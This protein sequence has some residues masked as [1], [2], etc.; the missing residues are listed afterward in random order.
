MRETAVNDPAW[1]I[2]NAAIF[3][4]G[5]LLLPPQPVG[6][7]ETA[8]NLDEATIQTLLKAAKDKN[9][10]VRG[11][12]ISILATTKDKKYV[13]LY[14][15]ALKDQ[16]YFV[17]DQAA[18]ALGNTKDDRAFNS[19]TK[20]LGEKSW[21]NKI[22]ISA[23]NGL[24]A[25]ADKRSL[26]IGIKYA[27]DKTLPSNSRTAALTVVGATGKGDSRAFP[28]IFDSFKTALANNSFQGINN[29]IQAII[30]LGD[31]R[32]QEAIDLL[33][34]KFKDNQQ[35]LSYIIQLEQQFKKSLENK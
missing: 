32:G 31:P 15:S 1:Q 22:E 19:L 26:E 3:K 5:K 27:G 6:S 35:F 14:V 8:V 28:L 10:Q 2:R 12:A 4:I 18:L 33:K 7:R 34:E 30:K 11:N 24:A 21:K 17:V 20:L 16:S 23:L 13:D 9:S 29:S 25:L